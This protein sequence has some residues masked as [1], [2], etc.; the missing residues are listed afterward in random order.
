MFLRRLTLGLSGAY[1]TCGQ[2]TNLM[3]IRCVDMLLQ[4]SYS[5]EPALLITCKALVHCHAADR[6]RRGRTT[7]H[8]ILYV[9][10]DIICYF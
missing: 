7:R 4:C 9:V 2:A 6:V 5:T 8:D 10:E 1:K 3:P